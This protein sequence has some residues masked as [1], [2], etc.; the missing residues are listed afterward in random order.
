MV[1]KVLVLVFQE[2]GAQIHFLSFSSL[3]GWKKQVM[4]WDECRDAR[5]LLWHFFHGQDLR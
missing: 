2:Y 3:S 5:L 1:L 4:E